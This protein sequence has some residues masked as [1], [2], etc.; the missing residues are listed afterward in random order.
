MGVT[1]VR[2]T[3]PGAPA[4]SASAGQGITVLDFILV[5]KLGWTK[6]FT[7]TNQAAYRQAGGYRRYFRIL[8]SSST[9]TI[10][11]GYE[12]M[13]DVSTGTEPFPGTA[14]S[15]HLFVK[16]ANVDAWVAVGD[17]R[18]VYF[19]V[20]ATSGTPTAGYRAGG[21]GDFYSYKRNDPYRQAVW[22]PS[23]RSNLTWYSN[24][25]STS[26]SAGLQSEI[27]SNVM[28]TALAR[29]YTGVSGSVAASIYGHVVLCPSGQARSSALSV[30]PAL[31]YGYDL[32]EVHV[33]ESAIPCVRGKLRGVWHWC[34]RTS[35]GSA[36]LTFAGDSSGDLAGKTFECFTPM[37]GNSSDSVF[38]IETS[39]T[40]ATN[41]DGA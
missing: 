36:G 34:Q 5:T 32:A 37:Q 40:W 9:N 35:D 39:D 22:A 14:D 7:G 24:I 19:A 27:G 33:G 17:S 13:T 2:S 16:G 31:D 41:T 20:H 18:T 4:L 12:T 10:V 30:A 11:T 23:N 21:L 3:D 15:A 29:S 6:E 1:V 25:L 26:Q 8:D 38:V 28:N